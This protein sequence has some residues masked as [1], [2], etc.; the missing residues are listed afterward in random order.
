MRSTMMRTSVADALVA[1]AGAAV[2]L[3]FIED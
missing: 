3:S 1:R 2:I